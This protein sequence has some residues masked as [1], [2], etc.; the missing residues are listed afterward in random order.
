MRVWAS[1]KFKRKETLPSS[2]ATVSC[3]AVRPECSLHVR[4]IIAGEDSAIQHSRSLFR[5]YQ[6]ADKSVN[7]RLECTMSAVCVLIPSYFPCE[8]CKIQRQL[9]DP[10]TAEPHE[11]VYMAAR[12]AGLIKERVTIVC[13]PPPPNSRARS[14]VPALW[15]TLC[16][17]RA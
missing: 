5:L 11:A 13:P 3:D 1:G 2:M 4:E 9:D 10:T 15:L 6:V 12:K 14:L 7:W 8:L 16:G 17:S